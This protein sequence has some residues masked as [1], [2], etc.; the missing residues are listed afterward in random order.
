MK[1]TTWLLLGAATYYLY[2][3]QQS[4]PTTTAQQRV[5]GADP[6]IDPAQQ[7]ATAIAPAVIVVQPDDH[8]D[9]YQGGGWRPSWG[10]LRS[11]GGRH[12]GGHGHGGGGHGGHH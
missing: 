1:I 3:Q 9:V 11:R 8:Y 6:A 2:R 5:S 4:T 10:D 12:H 7:G